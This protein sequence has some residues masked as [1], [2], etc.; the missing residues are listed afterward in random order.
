MAERSL[1]G[2]VSTVVTDVGTIG[3]SLWATAGADKNIVDTRNCKARHPHE[4]FIAL[5]T[6]RF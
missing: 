3:V 1:R 5:L 6:L 2:R 4:Q